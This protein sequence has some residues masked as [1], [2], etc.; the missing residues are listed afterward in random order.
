MT[1]PKAASVR[2]EDLPQ[3][4]AT[5]EA[6]DTTFMPPGTATWDDYKNELTVHIYGAGQRL[7]YDRAQAACLR[8]LLDVFLAATS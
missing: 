7:A 6:C 5:L 4:L 1:A 3:P 2:L 8:D